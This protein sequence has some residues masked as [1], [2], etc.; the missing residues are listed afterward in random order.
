MAYF[1]T[2]EPGLEGQILAAEGQAGGQTLTELLAAG[3]MPV[4]AALEL[5]ACCA[6]ILTIA[7]EDGVVHGA[8]HPDRVRMDSRGAVSIE[9]WGAPHAASVAPEPGPAGPA[10]DVYGIGIVLHAVLA[11]HPMGDIPTQR[12]D[13]D[14]HIVQQLMQL[15]W[16]ELADKRWM[17]EV[18]HF[19]CSML[20]HDP[21]E[22]DGSLST[23]RTS[24]GR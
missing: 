3:P 22:G 11:D 21:V 18:L 13:H 15:D 4:K 7:E 19:L 1:Y 2:R 5:V 6:D 12:D 23:W 16:Q 17:D 20:A 14:D 10:T 9:A 8:I 24:S